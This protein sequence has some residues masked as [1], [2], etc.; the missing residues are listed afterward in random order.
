VSMSFPPSMPAGMI[1]PMSIWRQVHF[2]FPGDC[3]IWQ[4]PVNG[5]GYGIYCS[6][7]LVRS[8]TRAHRLM[9]E[10]LVGP[11]PDG[12]TLDHL[13]R[14]RRC[15][16][17]SHLEPVTIREN[18]LRGE[19]PHVKLHRTNKCIRGHEFDAVVYRSS[20]KIQKYCKT[21]A[22]IRGKRIRDRKK[23]SAPC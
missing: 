8:H 19:S 1:P 16:N 10:L 21:C 12:L 7:T 22:A 6:E 17:P 9:Y 14:V 15:V 5:G 4:G 18:S 23:R 11:I 20:G 13:C 3:W 2:S